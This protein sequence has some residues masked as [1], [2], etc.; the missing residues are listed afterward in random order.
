MSSSQNAAELYSV[1]SKYKHNCN[2]RCKTREELSGKEITV[3][4]AFRSWGTVSVFECYAKIRRDAWRDS[5]SEEWNSKVFE[6]QE[7]RNKDTLL[8]ILKN[9]L[10]SPSGKTCIPEWFKNVMWFKSNLIKIILKS[11]IYFIV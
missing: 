2:A 10:K 9:H 5:V 3:G 8:V 1:S 4:N 7:L 11:Y 6:Q